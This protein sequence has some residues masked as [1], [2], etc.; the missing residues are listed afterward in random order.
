MTLFPANHSFFNTVAP[1]ELLNVLT[2]GPVLRQNK[3]FELDV[4]DLAKDPVPAGPLARSTTRN[5][6]LDEA[7]SRFNEK[8]RP[9]RNA[10]YFYL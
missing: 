1:D 3:E 8:G 7:E 10:L 6:H 4:V 5:S 2:S 9:L